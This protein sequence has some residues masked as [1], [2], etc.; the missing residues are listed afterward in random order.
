VNGLD[1][2][3]LEGLTRELD[4]WYADNPTGLNRP[5]IEVIWTEMA[6]PN[7]SQ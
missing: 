7:L 2:Y 4:Q 1:L 6:L 5:V 3:T